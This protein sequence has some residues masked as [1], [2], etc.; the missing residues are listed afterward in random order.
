MTDGGD[1]A[2]WWSHIKLPENMVT[3]EKTKKSYS[4]RNTSTDNG[5]PENPEK[6]LFLQ[7][8]VLCASD[9]SKKVLTCMGCV[10]REVSFNVIIY[11]STLT[12]LI[13]SVKDPKEERKTSYI[14]CN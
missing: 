11:F 2:Q 8:R 3:K 7:A 6:M 1:K 4:D 12:I 13:I 5:L 10:Q 14:N 9:P